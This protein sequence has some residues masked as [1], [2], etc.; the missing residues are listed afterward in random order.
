VVASALYR[1]HVYEQAYGFTRLRVLVSACELWLGVLFLFVL[2]AGVRRRGAW[3][4]RAAV[5]A[6]VIALLGLVA[7]DPDRFIADHNVDRYSDIGRIDVNY[8]STL[9][10]D[11]A[12]ALDR[13]PEDLRDCVLSRIDRRLEVRPDDDWYEANLARVRARAIFDRNPGADV[14]PGGPPCELGW[15]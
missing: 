4:P 5:G 15:R 7:L 1:M 14:E 8:L 12:P 9:S 13:L 3:L 10:A 2:A 6:A 11:A